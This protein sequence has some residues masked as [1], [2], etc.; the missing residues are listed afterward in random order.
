MMSHISLHGMAC[1]IPY[2]IDMF[3]L[4]SE[5]EMLSEHC[6]CPLVG[7]SPCKRYSLLGVDH[8]LW[9]NPFKYRVYT[10]GQ[11]SNEA[12]SAKKADMWP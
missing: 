5:C 7:S 4:E 3:F 2:R 12:V 9:D 10:C 6:M 8:P 1:R 11:R